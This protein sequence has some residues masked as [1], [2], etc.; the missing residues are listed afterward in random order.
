MKTKIF[1]KNKFPLFWRGLGGGLLL[2]CPIVLAAQNGV[3]VSNLAV[4]AGTITFNVN[5]NKATMPVEVW[6]DTV[7]VFVDYNDAGVM[8]RLPVADAT[9]SAGT[10]TKIAGNDKG[11]WV[12]GNAR[13]AGSFSA[14]VQLF[15][16][17]AGIAGACAYASNYPPVGKYIS[18]TKISFTGTPMY[19]IVIEDTDENTETRQS[20]NTFTVP[21]GYKLKSFSD[22]TG[23]PGIMKC[24]E[25]IGDIDFTVPNIAKNQQASFVVNSTIVTPDP[26]LI[27]Y[28]WSA[29]DFS[30]T[31]YEG[32]T[33]TSTA[34][35]MSGTYS[36]TLTARR[37]DYCDLVKTKD[38]EVL[39]CTTPGSTVTF[40]AFSP[41]S[42]ATTGD[43]W[44]LTD[45][46][47]SNNVQTYKVKKMTDGHIW[48]VQDLK[49]GDKCNKTTFTGSNGKDQ[50]GNITS[51]TD[52]TYYGDCTDIRNSSTPSN[53][54]YLYDWAAAINKSSAYSG[55]SAN[56]GCSGI[57]SGTVSP[58]PSSCQGICPTDWH[59]PTGSSSGELIHL[60]TMSGYTGNYYSSFWQSAIFEG[61]SYHFVTGATSIASTTVYLSSSY[62]NNSEVY[63]VC[64]GSD[65]AGSCNNWTIYK[66][67]TGALRCIM[68]Y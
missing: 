57:L 50:T 62:H 45:M 63:T 43:Y 27:T 3:T 36:V 34:P 8:K 37:D 13:N 35:T 42:N 11:V 40:A 46:R 39:E 14:T 22:K 61:S 33:F 41:C 15:T 18:A 44:Y 64:S 52:K 17:T 26:A 25:M 51:L 38:V 21:P 66:N 6:S 23:A 58:N 1:R 32:T 31:T 53:R 30:P 29:P 4:N 49:F 60:L 55:S 54:G 56:V 2:L 59:V 7:W 16:T 67:D 65:Y 28:S 20:G 10:V 47:E 19:D 12:V 5:W 48:M 24:I 9:A 68:N